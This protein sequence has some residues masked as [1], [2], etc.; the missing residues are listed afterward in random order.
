MAALFGDPALPDGICSLNCSTE[1]HAVN[2]LIGR[3][4]AGT[5]TTDPEFSVDWCLG[6][7]LADR[8]APLRAEAAAFFLSFSAARFTVRQHGY[9]TRGLTLAVR[10]DDGQLQ[11]VCVCRKLSRAERFVDLVSESISYHYQLMSSIVCDRIPKLF[12]DDALQAQSIVVERRADVA[13]GQLRTM[14]HDHADKPHWYVGILAVDPQHQGKG[15]GAKLCRAVSAM[16]DKDGLPCYL[17][18]SG[19]R[20]RAIYTHLGYGEVECYKLVDPAGDGEPYEELCA[21][22]RPAST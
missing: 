9:W 8:G 15:L 21:M 19:P 18:C 13:M 22:V 14:H 20:N 3:S 10:G 4:F 7:G 1:E 6:P 2:D 16:A 12:T 17:G 11:A 5:P